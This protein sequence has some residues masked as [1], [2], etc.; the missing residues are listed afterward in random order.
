MPKIICGRVF[1]GKIP[2]GLECTMFH[3]CIFLGSESF[4]VTRKTKSFH[5]CLFS[6]APFA[7]RVFN[8]GQN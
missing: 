2:D 8:P 7:I 1:I 3:R 6:N 4:Q 5:R